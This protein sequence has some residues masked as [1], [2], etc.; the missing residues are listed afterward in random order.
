MKEYLKWKHPRDNPFDSERKHK[1]SKLDIFTKKRS[2]LT[3]QAAAINKRIAR[4][5]IKG[6]CPINL[7]TG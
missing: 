4:M 7:V 5:I 3:E 2:C 6:V 1:Q